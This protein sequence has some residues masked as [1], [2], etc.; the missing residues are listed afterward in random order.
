MR[1]EEIGRPVRVV[2]LSFRNRD[3]QEIAT[4]V[5]D[6]ASKGADIIV[7]PEMWRGDAVETLE[8]PTITRFAFLARKH[9]TYIVCPIYRK[10]GER[11][12][13]NSAVLLDR[14]GEI[15]GVYDKVYPYWNEFNL[16]PPVEIGKKVPVYET[17]FGR[18][19]M[20]MCFDV[21]F[22]EVWKQLADHGAELV[23]WPSAYSGGICLQAHA[24]NHHF[25]IVTSTLVG[26][27]SVY[28]ITGK[29]ILYEKS[30]GVNISRC[31]LDLDRGIYHQNYNIEKRDKL[32]REQGHCVEEELFMEREQWFVLKAKQP[33]ISARGLARRYGLEELRD[34]L[35]R[36][37][38]EIDKLRG[39]KIAGHLECELNSVQ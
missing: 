29:E 20:A 39:C 23:V 4:L 22:P 24:I 15:V 35:A 7:L 21:N 9:G 25:Y 2:S 28:D 1:K 14:Q 33:N 3:M 12:R 6:E 34:Y 27:C 32:L 16:D 13:L 31:T 17:D 38:R 26:D 19:G 37:R 11:K 18:L 30:S 36:S 10:D 8:G 5:A